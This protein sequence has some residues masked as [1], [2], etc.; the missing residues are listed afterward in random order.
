MNKK[1]KFKDLKVGDKVYGTREKEPFWTIDDIRK[2]DESFKLKIIDDGVGS[3]SGYAVGRY[4][5]ES[6]YSFGRIEIWKI[7]NWRGEF[8]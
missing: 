4:N 3:V 6:V 7:T 5:I 8:E 2:S 1:P